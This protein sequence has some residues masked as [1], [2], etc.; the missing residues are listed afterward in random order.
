M[1]FDAVFGIFIMLG[2][3]IASDLDKI[4]SLIMYPVK[5]SVNTQ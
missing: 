2:V 3:F 5:H 1:K 4:L